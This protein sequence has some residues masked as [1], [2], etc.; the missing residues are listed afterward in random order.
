MRP[1][2]RRRAAP[3]HDPASGFI[4]G[5]LCCTRP[6]MIAR[7]GWNFSG[8]Q[9]ANFWHG[10]LTK[11]LRCR[12]DSPVTHGGG[13]GHRPDQAHPPVTP[14]RLVGDGQ[15]CTPAATLVGVVSTGTP[16][17]MMNR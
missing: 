2:Y 10:L 4:A 16:N 14:G 13:T 3:A 6:R 8:R 9:R 5:W 1:E 7:T 15:D 11:V 12:S 17:K